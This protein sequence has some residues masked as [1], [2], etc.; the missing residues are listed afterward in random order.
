MRRVVTQPSDP[1]NLMALQMMG[2]TGVVPNTLTRT[3]GGPGFRD[4]LK[5]LMPRL[6]AGTG[7]WL[8]GV[9]VA[10]EAVNQ[11]NLD[12]DNPVG[13]AA[14]F[15]GAT[16]GGLG[17]MALGAKLGFLGGGPIGAGIGGF[18]GATL[19]GNTL[20]GGA[21]MVNNFLQG[22]PQDRAIRDT[23]RMFRSQLGMGF[24]ALPLQQ[25]Q[26]EL[27]YSFQER[28]AREAQ[29]LQAQQLYQQAALGSAMAPVGRYM[30]PN[31][32]AALG[33]IGASYGGI[34]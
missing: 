21:N 26:S 32:M 3:A 8:A 29:R 6:P 23:E 4:T 25:A 28:A 27:A 2:Q 20:R 11:L 15:A 12:P 33:Q 31:F 19:G 30:D 13:N 16:G 1:Y 24:E 9:P 18:L 10:M 17:G 5:G 22:S 7:M 14:G 34:G